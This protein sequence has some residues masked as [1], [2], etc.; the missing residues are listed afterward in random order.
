M[1][2]ELLKRLAEGSAEA[3]V[4]L[5][6]MRERLEELNGT[7]EI[8][9]NGSGTTLRTTV[10]LIPKDQTV[11]CRNYGPNCAPRPLFVVND[12]SARGVSL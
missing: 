12:R 8:D 9:S 6:G 2:P 3:G 10:S 11:R 1:P 5:A 7:V 4:G